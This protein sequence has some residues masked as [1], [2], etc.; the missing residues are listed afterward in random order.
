VYPFDRAAA[1]L[2]DAGCRIVAPDRTG[3][4]RSTPVS[5]LPT[6][7]HRR[8]A[9]ETLA[10][11][12]ALGVARPVLW[13]HSDGAV[14]ALLAALANGDRVAGVVVEATHLFRRKPRSRP[15][16]DSMADNPRALGGRVT[17]VLAQD[18][19]DRWPEV[20]AMNAR[21]WIALADTAPTETADLYDG[22]L[23]Q[24]AVPVMVVHGARDQRTEPGEVDALAAMLPSPDVHILPDGEHSPHSETATAD[25]VV[26]A[27]REF[28]ARIAGARAVTREPA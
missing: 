2:A 4:G 3:Y 11:V 15:F 26:A 28:V 10:V 19:G 27:V 23:S 25:R 16:F 8:A 13:G 5:E 22:M 17:A 6:D 21:A 20:I 1:A 12:D 9:A 24:I 18:H 7:F 14:I